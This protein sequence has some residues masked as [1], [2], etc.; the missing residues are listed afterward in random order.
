MGYR[1]HG[2]RVNKDVNLIKR[3]FYLYLVKTHVFYSP[4]FHYEGETWDH[5]ERQQPFL[6]ENWF[7]YN[8]STGPKRVRLGKS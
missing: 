8:H 6:N 1:K 5:V 7:L 3:K 2:F 4:C